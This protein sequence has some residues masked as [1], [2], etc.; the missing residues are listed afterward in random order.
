MTYIDTLPEFR[1]G[2]S[3]PV[4][5]ATL[6]RDRMQEVLDAYADA[7][8]REVQQWQPIETAPKT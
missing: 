7:K 6:T 5:R 8:V 4:E 2:N 1:S 3:I